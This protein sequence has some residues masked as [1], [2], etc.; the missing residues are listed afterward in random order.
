MNESD[1][2]VNN[3]FVVSGKLTAD[4]MPGTDAC[5]TM[6]LSLLLANGKVQ[7]T[8]P[9][10]VCLKLGKFGASVSFTDIISVQLSDQGSDTQPLALLVDL[11]GPGI[12]GHS[13]PCS[14]RRRLLPVDGWA[15]L[16]V[17]LDVRGLHGASDLSGAWSCVDVFEYMR[18]LQCRPA[19]T[20]AL[21]YAT[22]E[23]CNKLERPSSPSDS[24]DEPVGACTAGSTPGWAL[25]THLFTLLAG[26]ALASIGFRARSTTRSSEPLQGPSSPAPTHTAMTSS[27]SKAV[28]P[29]PAWSASCTD[30]A[31]DLASMAAAPHR[32]ATSAWTRDAGRLRRGGR[33]KDTAGTPRSGAG[34]KVADG[35]MHRSLDAEE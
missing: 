8:S 10:P 20:E 23:R 9:K 31:P 29:P 35:T 6:A 33:G 26:A 13:Q 15:A 19:W 7:T 1:L 34:G 32:P 25:G 14:S 30:R 16:D 22:G 12:D 11:E 17:S 28:V 18:E 21:A 5:Y 4:V 2:A 24:A 27:C 3:H